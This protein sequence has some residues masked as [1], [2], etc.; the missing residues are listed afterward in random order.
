MVSI[1]V[2]VFKPVYKAIK[3][4]DGSRAAFLIMN[5]DVWLGDLA[6]A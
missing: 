4:I 6:Y 5:S 3:Q 1:A 2:G